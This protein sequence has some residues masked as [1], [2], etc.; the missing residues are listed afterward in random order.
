MKWWISSTNTTLTAFLQR[1]DESTTLPF[2]VEAQK[3]EVIRW[4]LMPEGREYKSFRIVRFKT[5]KPE[6]VEAVQVVTEYLS[7]D[8]TIL[9][10]KLMSVEAGYT[11]EVTWYYK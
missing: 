5:G 11:Y 7:D 1:G 3:S 2:V 8:F 4:F 6:N 9:A 10:Y